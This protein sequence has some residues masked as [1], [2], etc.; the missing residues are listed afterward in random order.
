MFKYVNCVSGSPNDLK[1]AYKKEIKCYPHLP[2][3]EG[4]AQHFGVL[5]VITSAR[6]TSLASA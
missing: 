1:E 4:P 6:G 2:C 3:S 5:R